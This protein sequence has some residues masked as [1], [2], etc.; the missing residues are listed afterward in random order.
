MASVNNDAIGYNVQPSGVSAVNTG[1][2][3]SG[4]V[5]GGSAITHPNE[6][7]PSPGPDW[8]DRAAALAA[9]DPSASYEPY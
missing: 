9:A 5:A 4:I 3:F 1:T 7:R 6:N 2:S 8:L